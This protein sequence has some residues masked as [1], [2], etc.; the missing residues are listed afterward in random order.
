MWESIIRYFIFGVIV[1][2][3]LLFIGGVAILGWGFFVVVPERQAAC[4]VHGMYAIDI[5]RGVANAC[6]DDKGV[7]HV[8]PRE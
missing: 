4:K 1:F 2:A 8:V 7:I 3:I 6:V 5:G